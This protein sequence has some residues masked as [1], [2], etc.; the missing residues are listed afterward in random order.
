MLARSDKNKPL[1]EQ[2]LPP[3]LERAVI[4]YNGKLTPRFEYIPAL[5]IEV[6]KNLA[7]AEKVEEVEPVAVNKR[8]N[9]AY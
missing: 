2:G 9:R 4:A 7:E 3:E 1:E 5:R 6:E 8:E